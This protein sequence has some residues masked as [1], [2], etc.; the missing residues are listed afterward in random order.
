MGHCSAALFASLQ[1]YH[2]H[3]TMLE[4]IGTLDNKAACIWVVLQCHRFGQ[5]FD[6]IKYRGHSAVVKEVVFV[7][8]QLCCCCLAGFVTVSWPLL[9][10]CLIVVVLLLF[11]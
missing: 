4:D 9:R 3:V 5:S 8:A 6:L 2:L 10:F 1:P 7:V 11:F